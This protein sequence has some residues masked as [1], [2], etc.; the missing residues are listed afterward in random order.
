M[1]LSVAL[2]FLGAA[3]ALSKERKQSL[4]DFQ[5]FCS[6]VEEGWRVMDDSHRFIHKDWD[7]LTTG[8]KCRGAR[9]LNARMHQAYE[10][11]MTSLHEP[12][13]RPTCSTS[14]NKDRIDVTFPYSSSS[15]P[16]TNDRLHKM[17]DRIEVW[18]ERTKHAMRDIN[19]A[20]ER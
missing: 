2:G 1:S 13:P 8:D 11:L 12:D 7:F 20:G 5:S 3:L 10:D 14:R 16:W 17:M 4:G 15:K 6:S 18:T 9:R 19:C